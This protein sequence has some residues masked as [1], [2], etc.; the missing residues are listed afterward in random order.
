MIGKGV[1]VRCFGKSQLNGLKRPLGSLLIRV[2]KLFN[3]GATAAMLDDT[4]PKF[5]SEKQMRP[6]LL[7]HVVK[8]DR[9]EAPSDGFAAVARPTLYRYFLDSR[10]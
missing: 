10:E 1:G 8:F 7:Q 6:S 9:A 5:L 2:Y 3:T 4:Q